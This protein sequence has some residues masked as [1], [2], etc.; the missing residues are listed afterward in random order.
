[1][2]RLASQL[3][4]ICRSLTG[5]GVR[6]TLA[7]LQQQ[8]LDISVHEVASG[9]PAFDWYI[10]EEW[11]VDEAYIEDSKGNRIVDFTTHNLHLLGY[12][13]P[14]NRTISLAELQPHLYSLPEQPDAIPYVTSYYHRRW[15]F[16]LTHRQRETLDEG[17]YRVVIKSQLKPGSMTYGELI[18]PGESP[19]EIL[20]STYVCHPSMANNE[21]SGPV[22]TTFLAKWLNQLPSRRYTYRIVFLPET[23]GSIYYISQHLASLK[24]NV[25]AGF[26]VTC[27]GDERTYSYLPSR[28]ENTLADRVAKHVLKH[29]DSEVDYYS[30]LDRGSD[31]RQ[32]CSPG[33]DLPVCS[34]MRS[35]YGTY[36]EYHTSLDDL[37]LVT[38]DGLL[39]GFNVLK[40]CLLLLEHNT[41][42]QASVCCEPQ[43]GRRGLYPTISSKDSANHVQDMMNLLAYA[44]GSLDLIGIGDKI[45]AYAG[46]L[47]PIVEKLVYEGLLLKESS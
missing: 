26:V 18:I 15:G 39:G 43:L 5:N 21:L 31:E 10:P 2:H 4:P 34:V 19:D 1:M 22:V 20:I 11:N 35:K 3:Y 45:N 14:V 16:C 12:S 24:K 46:N 8:G 38:S 29:L 13:E 32:Y 42:Y 33:V 44:D 23:I 37:N 25:K 6:Q 27:I 9:T 30:Y 17:Q 28:Q 36:P 40:S 41:R 7:I 47:L